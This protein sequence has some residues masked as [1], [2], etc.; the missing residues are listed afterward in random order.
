MC[1]I[2]FDF[3]NQIYGDESDFAKVKLQDSEV[4]FNYFAVM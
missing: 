1:F 3:H 4:L 2:R